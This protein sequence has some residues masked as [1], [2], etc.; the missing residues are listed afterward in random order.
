M[1]ILL[2]IYTLIVDLFQGSENQGR[3]FAGI[4]KNLEGSVE[5]WMLKTEGEE[6]LTK[7]HRVV[8]PTICRPY[9]VGSLLQSFE[10]N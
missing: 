2:L 7:D 8:Y 4:G 1:L 5:M 9:R 6:G 10:K 3:F